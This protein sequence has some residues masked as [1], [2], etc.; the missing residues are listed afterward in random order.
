[1]PNV[2]SLINNYNQR[3]LELAHVSEEEKPCTVHPRL[4]GPRLSGSSIYRSCEF[5]AERREST[6][7]QTSILSFFSNSTDES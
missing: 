5:A 2:G 6:I 3:I 4:S 1:M 7:K